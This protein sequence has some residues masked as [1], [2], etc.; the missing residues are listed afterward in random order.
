M[1]R[2]KAILL[3]GPTGS[4]KTPLGEAL[5]RHGLSGVKCRHFDFG[6]RLRLV[7]AGGAAGA[8]WARDEVELVR[9]LLERGALLEDEHFHL[10]RRLLDGFVRERRAGPDGLI[11]LNGLPRH[12]GQARD[13]EGLIGMELVVR[14]RCTVETILDRIE[15]DAGGD[16][17]GRSDDDAAAVTDRFEAFGKRTEPLVEHYRAAGIPVEELEVRPGSSAEDL[18]TALE[19]RLDGR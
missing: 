16:R 18:L 11:V 5:E 9:G 3:L 2:P 10:A 4:G 17:A 6:E 12:A 8:G 13:L 19:E 7:A 1:D 14:L 15:T